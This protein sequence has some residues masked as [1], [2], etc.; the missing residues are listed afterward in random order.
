MEPRLSDDPA[1]ED[2]TARARIREA[3]I[4]LFAEHGVEET[5]VL[6][7]AK[8]AGVSGGLIRHHFGSKDGLR[9]ACDTYVCS[10]LVRFK[11]E[12]LEKR[13]AD[14]DF[15][16]TFDARQVLL[17]RYFG[18]AMIDGSPAA[19]SR[20]DEIVDEYEQWF[21]DQ[22][23][24][25]LADARACAAV[26]TGMTI[27]VL[28][29]QDHIARALGEDPLSPKLQE[30]IGLAYGDIYSPALLPRPLLRREGLQ[31]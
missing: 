15:L 17:R 24:L 1:F 9:V 30:R 22:P 11:L 14:P 8:E 10:E 13:K 6:D 23:G 18:R 26:M 12:A 5:A 31:P 4:R 2:L 3:A 27:G 21:I 19:A 28:A 7:I 16:V 29:M 25:D 20:F